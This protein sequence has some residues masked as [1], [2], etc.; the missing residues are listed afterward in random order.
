MKKKYFHTVYTY[1][2]NEYLLLYE[3]LRIT[4]YSYIVI[5]CIYYL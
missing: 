2:N 5:I 1:G 3:L 4:L